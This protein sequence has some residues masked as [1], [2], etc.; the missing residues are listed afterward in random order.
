LIIDDESDLCS[1]LKKALMPDNYAVDCAYSLSE[2]DNK[3]RDHPNIILLDNN[4][5]D[6]TGLEYLQMHPVQ[7]MGTVVILI[8][9][10]ANPVLELKDRQEGVDAF[11]IKPFSVRSIKELLRQSA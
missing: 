4:L 11:I 7:F 6:G 5:P 10:D 2:A 1:L 3:L 9:A 8:T